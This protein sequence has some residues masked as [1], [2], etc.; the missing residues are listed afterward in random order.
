MAR[1]K[2][3]IDPVEDAAIKERLRRAIESKNLKIKQF[4]RESGMAYPSLRDYHGG[5]RKPGFEAIATLLRFTGV[6]ADWLILGK[7]VMFPEEM[8]EPA[9][10]DEELMAHIA[11]KVATAVDEDEAP[12]NAADRDEEDYL[13]SRSRLEEQARE[14][15]AGKNAVITASV[16]NRVAHL[17]DDQEREQAI[18]REVETVLRLNRTMN[19]YS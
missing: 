11:Q 8:G 2:A 1:R 10:V 5:L 16:Y 3:Q 15:T 7:G 9:N 17:R 4:A 13:Y 12:A 14:N 18:Q 6:S 19:R